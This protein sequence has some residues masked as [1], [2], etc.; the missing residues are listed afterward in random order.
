[1]PG[2]GVGRRSE[3][4]SGGGAKVLVYRVAQ[5]QVQ[6]PS[7]DRVLTDLGA[8]AGVSDPGLRR[9]R[10]EDAMALR[11]ITA[12]TT[13]V[14][15]AD[16]VSASHRPDEASRAAV[17]VA[18]NVLATAVLNRADLVTATREAA[19]GAAA[20]VAA[21]RRPEEGGTAPACTFVSA[22]VSGGQITVGWIGDSRAY[23]LAGRGGPPSRCLTTDDTWAGQAVRGGRQ[24]PQEA[25]GDGHTGTLW[26]WLGD[27]ADREPAQI[28]TLATTGNG[29][30][31]LCSD[32]LWCYLW[33]SEE[34][35][36]IVR[37]AASPL[38]AAEMLTNVALESGGRD[39]IT[40]VVVAVD[41]SS[42]ATQAGG[43][44]RKD[45]TTSFT[46]GSTAWGSEPSSVN[47]VM[48]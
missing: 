39:N 48:P 45:S 34:L 20:A 40:T 24:S 19:A 15:V 11:Q 5:P 10:N 13:V 9:T 16:G 32:G 28:A 2:W 14:A 3:T 44:S 17:D 27:T 30:V 31:L 4:V 43:S 46:W 25:Y 38:S 36:V 47:T 41:A 23:W 12:D 8:A 35:A 1:M 21:L 26:R 6:A 42:R 37:E 22:V 33:N 7:R 29:A 18:V